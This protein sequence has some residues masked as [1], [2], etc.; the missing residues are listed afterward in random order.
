MVQISRILFA[1]YLVAAGFATPVKRTVAQIEACI[2][3]VNTDLTTMGN[4]ING[5]PASGLGGALAIH[6]AAGNLGTALSAGT[7]ALVSTG[8]LSEAD[9]QVIVGSISAM[10]S[11]ILNLLNQL[12]KKKAGFAALPVGGIPAEVLADLQALKTKTT[13]FSAALI[14]NSPAGQVSI[15]TSIETTIIAGFNTAIAEYE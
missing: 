15:A 8:S 7:S 4:A 6:T 9:G 5:F 13:A 14:A 3:N 1:A 12:G 11:P 10:Q 2:A